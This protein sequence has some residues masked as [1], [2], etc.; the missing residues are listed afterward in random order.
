M[1]WLGP[2]RRPTDRR[3]SHG[4]SSRHIQR[5]HGAHGR[6]AARS[7]SSAKKFRTRLSDSSP[8]RCFPARIAKKTE[9]FY[10]KS[11]NTRRG[12]TPAK[13]PHAPR[14]C[15]SN[16]C[17]N[18]DQDLRDRY[19]SKVFEV[20]DE[21]CIHIR[22]KMTTEQI[23]GVFFQTLFFFQFNPS[24][25]LHRWNNNISFQQVSQ[26]LGTCVSI[27]VFHKRQHF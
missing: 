11:G 2:S 4:I 20:Q 19:K 5:V 7:P 16:D 24:L 12:E 13:P 10:R 1:A 6:A 26:R 25:V 14:S 17:T 18:R 22:R 21:D 23:F 3:Q 15:C 9:T 8:A 27:T